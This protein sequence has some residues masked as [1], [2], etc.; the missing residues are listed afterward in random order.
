[1]N[2]LYICGKASKV[3]GVPVAPSKYMRELVN[4][5]SLKGE[6]EFRALPPAQI[7]QL[8][9]AAEPLPNLS[10]WIQLPAR[11]G[12][13]VLELSAS[14]IQTYES[15]PLSY[16]L[17]YDWRLPEDASAAL[18][19]GNAMHLALKAYFDGLRADRPPDEE[20]LVACFLG[21]FSKA[22]I[23]DPLQR[24]LYEKNGREQLLA[25]VRSAVA[26][27]DGEILET[28]RHFKIEIEGARVKGR[29]DRLDRLSS[30]DVSIIDYKTG[31]P[32]TQDD[33]DD[34]LQLSIYALAAKSLGHRP[35]SL[36]FINLQ[37]S[38]AVGSQRSEENLKHAEHKISEVAAKI[39][40][41]EFTAKPS[42]ACAWCSYNSICPE[43]EEP[44]P[45]PAVQ[46]AVSVH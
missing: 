10:H 33:A 31:K 19:F 30:G 28:E 32:K 46:R 5:G 18:Q 43:Q 27:P 4:A 40:A 3:K 29:L 1:M 16:K 11:G 7:P 44:Q 38:T 2:E 24:E 25:L 26:H 37:N 9:A 45:R 20:T 14:A 15:C 41:G 42:G 6:I 12:G 39:A 8:H 36:V 21:E 34:S 17:R 35:S 23:D 22:S 13:Q